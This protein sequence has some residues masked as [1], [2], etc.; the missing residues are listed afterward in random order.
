MLEV[1]LAGW[2]WSGPVVWWNPVAGLR[3]AFSRELRPRPGQERD[4]LCGQWVTLIDPSE[5]DW[6]LP[7]CDICMSVAVEHGREKEDRERQ[8]RR[9]VRE[10]FGCDGDAL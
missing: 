2:G 6:L 3:H 7:T 4:T 8:A 5:L 1:P 10:R 9:H